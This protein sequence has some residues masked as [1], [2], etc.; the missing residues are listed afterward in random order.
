[1]NKKIDSAVKL[2]PRRKVVSVDCS[3][4]SNGLVTYYELTLECGHHQTRAHLPRTWKPPKTTQCGL[5][6]QKVGEKNE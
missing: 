5:C 3:R 6:W 4:S 1:M 2:G